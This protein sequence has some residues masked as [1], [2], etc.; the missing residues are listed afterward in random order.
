[1]DS[2]L[3]LIMVNYFSETDMESCFN[4]LK[5]YSPGL[6]YH[7]VVID[8]GSSGNELEGMLNRIDLGADIQVIRNQRNV[9]FARACNQGIRISRG[10]FILLLNPDT[11]F[12]ENSIGSMMDFLKQHPEAGAAGCRQLFPS[13][14]HY[15]GDAGYHPGLATA[16]N[17]AFFLSRLFP[18]LF[19]GIYLV[20][21]K[22]GKNP[23]K[24]DWVSGG[25][26]LVRK[27][28]IDQVGAMDE[29]FF[30]YSED[31]EW[32]ARIRSH[33]WRIYYLPFIR[34]IHACRG[35]RHQE[36]GLWL[37][38]QILLYRRDHPDGSPSLFKW[39]ILSGLIL[40]SI[41]YFC[42]YFVSR[43]PKNERKTRTLLQSVSSSLKRTP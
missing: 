20:G 42:F 3:S 12:V 2:S 22:K 33:G 36:S 6:K 27:G 39:T 31:V 15:V 1:M 23:I 14:K 7:L 17:H 32:C 4:S 29:T 34:M 10:E 24:V 35:N 25:C 26:L 40:R 41:L 28:V 21:E 8:N 16:F 13:G 43:S 11:L 30:L 19:K 9:G 18:R 5:K 38:N 37:K